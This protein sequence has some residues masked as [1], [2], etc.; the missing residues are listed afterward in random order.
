MKY[1]IVF[2]I[3]F[4]TSS[5]CFSQDTLR[6]GGYSSVG[7]FKNN[8]PSIGNVFIIKKRTSSD[9]RWNGGNDY[10]VEYSDS[11]IN[12]KNIK[13]KF[14]AINQG[15][16]LFINGWKLGL[17]I[18]YVKALTRGR[19]ICL[20]GWIPV[21]KYLL[22]ELRQ[23][24]LYNPVGG[25]LTIGRPF[26]YNSLRFLYVYDVELDKL[27]LL[28]EKNSLNI[29]E[30]HSVLRESFMTESNKNKETFIKYIELLNKKSE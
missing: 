11:N 10:K 19:F 1:S 23:A 17:G 14:W 6:V 30:S 29:L 27:R 15:D 13:Y 21:S 22:K 3:F 12:R 25:I 2:L 4:I 18:W 26:Q 8:S 16:I 20:E 28:D 5:S 7:E 24:G 9:I